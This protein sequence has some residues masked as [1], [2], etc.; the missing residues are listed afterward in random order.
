MR[1]GVRR[2]C[3]TSPTGGG[4][5]R[6]VERIVEWGRPTLV[7]CNRTL[8][9]EQW[10]TGFDDS[11][12]PFGMQASGYAPSVFENCQLG[13]VQTIESRWS[14]RN[15]SLPE[16]EIVILDEAHNE[17]G[18]RIF[19]MLGEYYDR[20]ATIILVTATPVGIGAMADELIVAG[21]PSEL[22][23]LGA[24][25]PAQTFA[26]D[27]PDL[28]AF[29]GTTKGILQFRDEI[30]EIMLRVVFGR[31]I[32]HYHKLNPNQAP[33]ILFAPG[34]DESRW[35]CEQFNDHGIPWSHIDSKM[36]ILNGCELPATKENRERL[37][38]A[39]QSGETKGISNRFV[40]REGINAPWLSHGIFACTFG[41]VSSYIQAGGRL[42]RAFPGLRG[43]TVQDH[44]GN[45]WRHDSLNVDREWSLDDTDKSIQEKHDEAYRTKAEPEP[46]VCPKCAKVRSQG[47]SCPYCGFVHSG[48]R[49]IV[50]Q[51]DGTLREV[52]GDVYKPRRVND[53]P[54]AHK[55]WQQCY[56]RCK[57]SGRTFNQARALF[58]HETGGT[59]PGPGFPLM[60][61]FEAD[62]G[63]KV[64]DVPASRLSQR[65]R[66]EA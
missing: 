16:A 64:G 19:K 23:R 17:K 26:P 31:V 20:G 61:K 63:L 6:I 24:L 66:S 29:K 7:L 57:N 38:K 4:K 54:E 39:S 44:G 45:F 10:A 53:S 50:V 15:E 32:E 46:I 56:Y 2:L 41:S 25:V 52:K 36:I 8:L 40:L 18:E 13:M 65:E 42:L 9:L 21:K 35:L 14:K 28:K 37:L 34:V 5:T 47:A 12:L 48:R 49:R 58:M 43:V 62:W 3:I 30:K 22:F 59:V 11:G 55:T 27:E 1:A 33:S 60:P 51:T